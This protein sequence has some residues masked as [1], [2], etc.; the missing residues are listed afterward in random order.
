MTCM[1]VARKH[2]GWYLKDR[3]GSDA[4]RPILMR[5]EDAQ[6]QRDA[7]QAWFENLPLPV[8]A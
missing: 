5:I 2:L 6:Q 3:E 8:A 4:F 1:R 7:V